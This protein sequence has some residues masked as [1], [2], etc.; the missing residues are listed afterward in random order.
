MR[1]KILL[2]ALGSLTMAAASASARAE[3]VPG[4]GD[5]P[6]VSGAP[7]GMHSVRRGV[8]A[9]EGMFHSRILLHINTSKGSVAE[10]ISL[11]PDFYYAVTDSLQLGLLHN[12]PMGLLTKPGAGL[13]LTGASGGCASGVYRNVGWDLLYGIL[14]GD[15]HLSLHS[16][17]LVGIPDPSPVLLTVGLTGKF[18]FSDHVALFFDPQVGIAVS[19][20]K[21]GNVDQ[22]FMPVELQFQLGPPVALKILSG[23]TGPLEGFSKA[24]EIPLGIAVVGNLSKAFDLGVRFAFHNLA[25]YIPP[26]GSRTGA[27]SL[28]LLLHLRF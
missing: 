1:R 26:G 13:C 18:H 5:V 3:V 17:L 12:Q 10:P 7:P 2:V 21:A 27:S 14:F 9:P 8:Q 15:V 19:D 23:L 25:G 16:S 6:P 22:F 4:G 20:R 28:T 24:Y 11:A